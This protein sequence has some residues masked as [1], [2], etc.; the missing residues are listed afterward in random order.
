MDPCLNTPSA[1]PSWW[2]CWHCWNMTS[3]GYF[4]WLIGAGDCQGR[5]IGTT[6]CLR[7][8]I[9]ESA[10]GL[11]CLLNLT[12]IPDWFH[13]RPQV[14]GS[15]MKEVIL[16]NMLRNIFWEHA[17]GTISKPSCIASSIWSLC[18]RKVCVPLLSLCMCDMFAIRFFFFFVAVQHLF[19]RMSVGV[20]CEHLSTVCMLYASVAFNIPS[21]F[22]SLFGSIRGLATRDGYSFIIYVLWMF[23]AFPDLCLAK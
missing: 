12:Y 23:D 11:K 20:T 16:E 6:H 3:L 1:N 15:T 18:I 4:T 8:Q 2:I 19:D 7:P 10:K 5:S 22:F 17:S 9:G 13:F 21:P 14:L